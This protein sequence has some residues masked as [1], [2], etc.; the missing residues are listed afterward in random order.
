MPTPIPAESYPLLMDLVNQTY[1]DRVEQITAA[2]VND[3]DS[4]V[5]VGLDNPKK[6]AGKITDDHIS[7]KL[8]G[9][10]EKPQFAAPKKKPKNC[11]SPTSISCGL[12][13]LPAKTKAGKDTVCKK[14]ISPNQK[15][16]KKSI[17]DA[18]KKTKQ[19]KD[20]SGTEKEKVVAEADQ[21]NSTS[22]NPL[23][24]DPGKIADNKESP[25]KFAT[26]SVATEDLKSAWSK[27]RDAIYYEYLKLKLKEAKDPFVVQTLKEQVRL[28]KK[29]ANKDIGDPVHNLRTIS[30]NSAIAH[31]L[32]YSGSPKIAVI[33][34]DRIAAA[35]SYEEDKDKRKPLHIEFLATAPSNMFS[36]T[37]PVKGAGAAA[38]KAMVA[39]SLRQ[40]KKGAV[41]LEPLTEAI[42]F[43]KKMGFVLRGESM[44]LSAESAKK[45]L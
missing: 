18:A 37:N 8:M 5:F 29:D 15:A 45:H 16:Q 14:P 40:G 28:R 13:C 1:L 17:V 2:Q 30:D 20:I 31:A 7:M 44:V 12:T 19:P 25:V 21:K 23:K 27:D 24:P 39:E 3:D 10:G 22:A 36:G 43:Y 32:M 41:K 34:G 9:T 6:I 11:S 33:N 26:K 35:F 4:I 42:G 38:V